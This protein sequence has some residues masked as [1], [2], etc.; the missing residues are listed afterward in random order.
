MNEESRLMFR[1]PKI[2]NKCNGL[3]RVIRTL[4][5]DYELYCD[6]FPDKSTRIYQ[7]KTN[8]ESKIELVK[9]IKEDIKW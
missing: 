3:N 7:H 2:C 1:I 9:S 8:Y 4:G 5:G 6:C